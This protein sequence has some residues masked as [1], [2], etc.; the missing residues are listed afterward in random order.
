ML[1][2]I[3]E[4][5]EV[6]GLGVLPVTTNLREMSDRVVDWVRVMVVVDWGRVMEEVD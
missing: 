1:Q 5:A 4:L 3:R 2:A 6:F